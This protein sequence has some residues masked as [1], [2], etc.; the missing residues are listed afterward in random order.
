MEGHLRLEFAPFLT[1]LCS[2]SLQQDPIFFVS[3]V[4]ACRCHEIQRLNLNVTCTS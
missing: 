3:V 1:K 2:E 4:I